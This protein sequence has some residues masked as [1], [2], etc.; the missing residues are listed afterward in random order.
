MILTISKWGNSQGVRFPKE[1]LDKIHLVIGM[2][3]KAEYVDGKIII[4]PVTVPKKYTIKQLVDKIPA[5]H[6]QTEYDW[7]VEGEEVW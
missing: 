2:H 7:G 1:L 3:V 5:T 4:E 6:Q